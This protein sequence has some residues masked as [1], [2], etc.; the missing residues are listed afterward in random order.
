M[1]ARFPTA[2]RD[3][4][5]PHRYKVY[6]GG[7][8]GAKS[9]ACAR[10]TIIM[11]TQRPLRVLCTREYQTSM[12]DS[13]H[14]LL[15]DQIEALGLG[16]F[17]KVGQREIVGLNGTTF[18]FE[19][20]R[21]NVTK[22]RSMEG[23][24][25][26][27]CEEAE[28]ISEDSWRILIPTIRAPGSEI[29]VTFNPEREEDPTYQRF[30]VNPPPDS[31][32]RFVSYRDNPWFPAVLEAERKWDQE[33]MDPV[34]YSHVWEGLPLKDTE[35]QILRGKVRVA[36]FEPGNDWE[37][38][39]HGLDF[40]FSNDPTASTRVWVHNG[41]LF[42][43]YE[44]GSADLDIDATAPYLMERIPGIEH[45]IIRADSARPESISYLKRHGLPRITSVKKWPG[46]VE[47]GIQH[48]R[49]YKEIVVHPRCPETIRETRLYSYKVDK[50][51]GDP[52]RDIVD[53]H[54]DFIDSVRYAL[55]PRI[56]PRGVMST[57]VRGLM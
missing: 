32:V 55:Q 3:L 37:G 24:D 53:A 1:R 12:R 42:I 6:Y 4:F 47:D 7:R 31:M 46:S 54:N 18:L 40:G 38:P 16:S 33:H 20:L 51:T 5:H 39:Y 19:G 49:S 17:Y 15:S 35:A 25:I 26:C 8:G 28:R 9:W 23:I 21:H 13:V 36:E 22:I 29:W 30:I 41:S 57:R 44:A 27:W 34:M 56:T 14:R 10:A 50:R 48:L 2:F 52:L 45:Y 11:G 43:E